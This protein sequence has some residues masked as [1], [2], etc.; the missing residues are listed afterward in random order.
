MS[1]RPIILSKVAQ[2]TLGGAVID[3][4]TRAM[5]L[6]SRSPRIPTCL[7]SQSRRM[8]PRR[9]DLLRLRKKPDGRL[10]SELYC[11]APGWNKVVY[12]TGLGRPVQIVSTITKTVTNTIPLAAGAGPVFGAQPTF[13]PDGTHLAFMSG[14]D[15]V[16]FVNTLTDTVE[17]TITLPPPPFEPILNSSFFF[18]P[19]KP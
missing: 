17:S 12:G 1:T 18:V 6:T 10:S 8:E 7:K 15:L 4:A 9:I 13:T 11:A 2:S 3:V 19:A 5:N 16:V 14:M